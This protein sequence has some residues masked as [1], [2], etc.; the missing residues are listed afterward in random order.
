MENKK[1]RTALRRVICLL[2][3]LALAA[4]FF[5]GEASALELRARVPFSID[6]ESHTMEMKF[7]SDTLY[8]RADQLAG[9]AGCLWKYNDQTQIVGFYL[10]TPVILASRG[11]G[12]YV[13][14]GTEVWVPF[15]ENA[16]D[17]G[18]FFDSVESGTVKGRRAT[19]LAV[20]FQEMDR[21]YSVER[22][23]IS[24]LMFLM[25]TGWIVSSVGARGYAILSAGLIDGF[26]DA[27]SG[28]MDQDMYNDIFVRMLKTDETLLDAWDR[29]RKGL[30][31]AGK[32]ADFLRKGV[33]ENGALVELLRKI[34]LNEKQIQSFADDV[35]Q[36][37]QDGMLPDAAANLYRGVKV[38]DLEKLLEIADLILAAAEADAGSIAAIDAVFG[39]STSDKVRSAAARAIASRTGSAV[40]V[41]GNFT[42][43]Y[44]L[45]LIWDYY[46][47][48]LE[49]ICKE[50]TSDTSLDELKLKLAVFLMDNVLGFDKKS[51][52]I[53]YSEAYSLLQ[54]D[55]ADYY[56]THCDD[57]LPDNGYRMHAV[58]MLYLRS[59]Y[60]AYKMYEFDNTM[61][62]SVGLALDTLEA[63][64]TALASYTREEL[65]QDGTDD[66]CAW[67]IT[68]LTD[69]L[70]EASEPDPEPPTQPPTEPPT[71]PTQPPAVD[72]SHLYQDALAA[73]A[74][75]LRQG[76]LLS[77]DRG[78]YVDATHYYLP[79]MNGDI[80]PELLA[81][82]L[83]DGIPTFNL[84]A[85]QNGGTMWIAD[86]LITC[87]LSRW[88]NARNVLS[89]Y[90]GQYIYAHSEKS[91]AGYSD[92]STAL[93]WYDGE[94][95]HDFYDLDQGVYSPGSVVQLVDYG[96]II[97]GIAIGSRD[98]FL[99]AQNPDI[100]DQQPDDNPGQVQDGTYYYAMAESPIYDGSVF[101]V[102]LPREHQN[103]QDLRP[104]SFGGR[105]ARVT[106]I[107]QT[108][109]EWYLEVYVD[110]VEENPDGTYR[111]AGHNSREDLVFI[112]E[113]DGSTAIYDSMGFWMEGPATI[114]WFDP[115]QLELSPDC[116]FVDE[117]YGEGEYSYEMSKEDAI[118]ALEYENARGAEWVDVTI[119]VENGRITR[120]VLPYHP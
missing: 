9:A 32:F 22:Y 3:C 81:F 43:E 109:Y 4:S 16:K 72:N 83:S 27:L 64:I 31:D 87:D 82:A 46:V 102:N 69:S 52:A 78:D 38:A 120:L 80:L 48:A 25:D 15:F 99:T 74:Q 113:S 10:D 95:A 91:T 94:Y 103:V 13:L 65:L 79:D 44:A 42:M 2:L 106:V 116:V 66:D 75:M 45:D 5:P 47:K 76:I 101:Y 93:I 92:S 54:L 33:E 77:N 119:G 30:K 37:Y 62:D 39:D 112:I 84:Y 36:E 34:G 67:A 114:Q 23:R 24:E 90:D 71:M 110:E 118:Y 14:E 58:T 55:I 49:D 108:G 97:G 29:E 115:A 8:C 98:D 88:Y 28:K 61:K 41:A 57:D 21:I 11:L 60:G 117:R 12:E 1:N 40:Q 68:N 6:G 7:F 19:P 59:C 105:L 111:M 51:D 63:E 50:F 85:Y 86:S 70:M 20:I 104:G 17:L 96:E 100:P 56:Y 73:Y 35:L 53:R 107:E 18:M 89:V 26:S